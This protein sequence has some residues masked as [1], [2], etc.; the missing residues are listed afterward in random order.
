MHGKFNF[1]Y[2]K[3]LQYLRQLKL[4]TITLNVVLKSDQ[5]VPTSFKI[6]VMTALVTYR[7][8]D[9][10]SISTSVVVR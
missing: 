7:Q 4:Q 1:F 3:R 8:I 2:G 5:F 9:K 6:N 10:L